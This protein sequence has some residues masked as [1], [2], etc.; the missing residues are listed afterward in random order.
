MPITATTAKAN[1]RRTHK[2]FKIEF[3][4]ATPVLHA[5]A[6]AKH[7][8]DVR[9]LGRIRFDLAA[10]IADVT[11][12][13]ALHAFVGI[14]QALLDQ[15]LPRE[16]VTRIFHQRLQEIEFG[17][18]QLDRFAGDLDFVPIGIQQQLADLNDVRRPEVLIGCGAARRARAPP[19]RA[20]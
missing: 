10:Q 11:V 13:R 4:H 18:R 9:R 2:R 16:G 1:V 14:A 20:D 12:E 3:S 5:I 8:F 17:G 6:H 15:G 7:G 19:L